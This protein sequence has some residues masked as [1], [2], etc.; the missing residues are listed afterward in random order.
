MKKEN[1]TSTS[2]PRCIRRWRGDL[3]LRSLAG[4]LRAYAHFLSR[5]VHGA[6]WVGFSSGPRRAA[7]EP[8]TTATTTQATPHA[9]ARGKAHG[10]ASKPSG[11]VEESPT[12]PV[13]TEHELNL[14]GGPLKR[15]LKYKATAGFIPLNDAKGKLRAN[16]FFMSYELADQRPQERPD[17]LRLQRRP[18]R[19]VGLAAPW[20]AGPKRVGVPEDGS[21][22]APPF[23][24]EDNPYTWLD[25]TDLVFIDPVGTG[26]S[27]AEGDHAKEFYSVQ[28]DVE[29]VADVIRIYLTTHQRWPSPKFIAGESY[30]TTRAAGLSEYLHDRFGI[31]ANGIVLISTVLNFQTLEFTAGNDTPYP[32]WLPS[33][34]A[35]AWYHKKLPADLQNKPLSDVVAEAQ[36][37]AVNQYMTGL[38]KGS[39]LDDAARSNF[40]QQLSRY[41]GL[42]AD[43][44]SRA[45]LRVQPNRFE[46]SLL[47]KER[48]IIGR[49]DGRISAT[50]PIRS[51]TRRNS[52]RA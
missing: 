25:F 11:D 6:H 41:T 48:K 5:L 32:L 10:P 34:T 42:P 17:H 16:V 44:V 35:I 2:P 7:E 24:L 28:G 4:I 51:T 43:Y 33:Y 8:A 14:P 1:R 31:D 40:I 3:Q 39:S 21:V 37:W 15:T 18:R 36:Q 52:I 50:T 20:T 9:A 49:M 13:V 12:E 23:H 19:C 46:K 27:R 30:G 22:P 47:S 38:L 29:S 45:E 26:Y